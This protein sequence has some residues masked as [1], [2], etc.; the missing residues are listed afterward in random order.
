MCR[1]C[2]PL[3]PA[4][5]ALALALSLPFSLA[6]GLPW[7]QVRRPSCSLI[8][9]PAQAVALERV[10]ALK[11]AEPSGG[12]QFRCG[13]HSAPSLRQLHMHVISQ[14]SGGVAAAA[15]APWR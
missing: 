11:A 12:L 5:Q 10:S 2:L 6:P 9:A 13:F 15:A 4:G 14:V 8:S 3:T 7:S 1:L